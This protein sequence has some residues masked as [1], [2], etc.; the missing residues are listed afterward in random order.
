MEGREL[1]LNMESIAPP[2][3][4]DAGLELCEL[5]PKSIMEAF[6]KAANSLKSRL[7]LS[8]D[9]DDDEDERSGGCCL[10]NPSPNNG[11]LPDSLIAGN[12]PLC[13]HIQC[14]GSMTKGVVGGGCGGDKVV[15]IGGVGGGDRVLGGRPIEEKE[16]K[17]GRT[18]AITQI[19]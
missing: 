11:N 19:D 6:L 15:V 16:R 1:G 9:D 4:D 3:L 8:D 18:Q 5:P 7:V 12:A 2:S 14:G 13:D 10:D 17:K